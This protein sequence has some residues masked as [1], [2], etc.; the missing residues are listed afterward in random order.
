MS[1]KILRM[2]NKS[3]NKGHNY[4]REIRKEFVELGFKK[5][6]TSRYG[7][8]MLDDKGIDLMNTGVFAVQCKAYARNPNYRK[9]FDKM[10]YE[11]TDIPIIF[12]KAPGNKQYCI[13]KKEDLMEILEMLI[14][15]DIIKTN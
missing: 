3:R 9:V 15:N 8:K 12:H 4:E 11:D 1:T 14:G 7:S 2:A 6:V 5:C 10:D 13:L